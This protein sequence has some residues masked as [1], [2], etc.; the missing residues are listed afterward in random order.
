MYSRRQLEQ[1]GEPFGNSA[2]RIEVNKRI[3]GGGGGGGDGGGSSV[4]VQEIPAELKPLASAYTSKAINLSNQPYTPY[5]GQRYADLNALQNTGLGMTAARAMGGSQTVDN[6]ENSLNQMISGT[7]NPYLDS[8]VQQAQDSVRSNFTT[9]AIN[10]GSFGNSGQQEAFA[11]Q[12]GNVATNMYG[13]AYQQDRANQMQAIGMAPTF[14]NLAYQD[15][16]QLMNAGQTLQD[17]DQQ[18]RDFAY[19]QFQEA[20]NLPYKQLAAMSGVF[21]SNL[22]GVSKTESTSSSGGGK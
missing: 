6:A 5:S 8:M 17:Q 14:G 19:Q 11:K 22:G 20:Q 21:G 12:L 3:Y 1:F 13:N 2:T 10:S 4:T 18:N 7:S 9:S 15:A 16:A